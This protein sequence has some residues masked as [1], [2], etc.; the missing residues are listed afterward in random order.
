[1]L[2]Y[3]DRTSMAHSLE[4]RVP[5]LDHRLVEFCA[6][7]P[8]ALK[9]SGGSTKR[10]LRS[11]ARGLVPDQVIDRPKVGFFSGA[12]DHWFRTPVEGAVGDVLLDPDARY[13]EFISRTEVE[14]LI[15]ARGD[16]SPVEAPALDPDVG[17]L[18]VV[19]SSEGGSATDTDRSGTMNPSLPYAL[20]TPVR[21]EAQ[22]LTRLAASIDA[23][24][25]PPTR[26]VIVDNG[27]EDDTLEVA[28]AL[29][30]AR[31]WVTVIS[32]RGEKRAVPGA[33][34]VRAFHAGLSELPEMPDI[35]V[36]LD[37]DTSMDQDHFERLTAAFAEDPFLGIASGVC[38]ELDEEG[39][40]RGVPVALGH[41]RGAVRAYRR[42]CLSDVLPLE[43][44][45]G[46]DGIDG[47]KA[48]VR[49]WTTKCCRTSPSTTTALS[50]PA[51]GRQRSAG[52]HKG[53]RHGS[54][55]TDSHTSFFEPSTA[56]GRTVRRSGCSKDSCVRLCGASPATPTRRCVPT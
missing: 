48:A 39:S 26:W 24:T 8:T 30:A 41:V 21:T 11:V 3:F 35:V 29:E 55:A 47:W 2:H 1:M 43:E 36:K 6:R 40:W 52:A 32:V 14:R 7:M 44:R 54:W 31:D 37:A 25:H 56:L 18:A 12:V 23:Q 13:S 53:A 15:A 27:S 19:I 42:E 51:T 4:V 9:L 28:H 5:Y 33:P 38:L 22:N 49:G 16:L 45:V 50:A 46:W 17:V 34:V 10:I 20:V